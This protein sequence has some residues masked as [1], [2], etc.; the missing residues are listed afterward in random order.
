VDIAVDDGD[1]YPQV[2][3]REEELLGQISVGVGRHLDHPELSAE[4]S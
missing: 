4:S 2:L 1:R 3:A